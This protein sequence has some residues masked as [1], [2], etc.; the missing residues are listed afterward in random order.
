MLIIFLFSFTNAFATDT[1][2]GSDGACTNAS[3][4][5]A[6][7]NYQCTTLTIDAA[8][9]M[10]RA[11]GGNPLVIKVQRDVYI[12]A[13]TGSIDLSGANGSS[14]NSTNSV[15]A[16]GAP[17]AGGSA[18]GNSPGTGADGLSG[19]GSGGGIFGKNVAP[20]PTYNYSYGGGGGGGS[21]K[22]QSLILPEIGDD[23]IGGVVGTA[24]QNGAIFGNEALFDSSFV[25]G[26]GGA[27]GGGGDAGVITSIPVTGS[28]GGGGGGALRI[29]AGGDITVDGNI[30]AQGGQGGGVGGVG[31]TPSSGGG[32]GGSGGA[33]WL[34]AA[35]ALLVSG[36]I[37][38][39]GGAVGTNDSGVVGLGGGGGDG[40]IRLDDGD[41]AIVIDPGGIVSPTAF[42]TTFTPTSAARQ[43]SSAVSC[44]RVSLQDE[45]QSFN[46]IFNMILG[47]MIASAFYFAFSR[48]GK[49]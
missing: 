43:Y 44:A 34:Q 28:S 27:A 42:S 15:K 48:R 12:T 31:G 30:I 46:T 45:K 18:G 10:F 5:V 35:G 1:G 29:I 6:K 20:A 23:G 16:G 24:G 4:I 49:V 37:T 32:G 39:L 14:G 38:A 36:S 13:V 3:F 8:L 19:S 21:Y 2:D 17:G 11:V 47:L 25:G 40:R 9:T 41:G 33:I 22:T 26:S 7:R